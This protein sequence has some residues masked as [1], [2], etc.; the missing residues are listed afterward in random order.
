MIQKRLSRRKFLY[1]ASATAI[2]LGAAASGVWYYSRGSGP[3]HPIKIGLQ[4]DLTGILASW[5]YW[6]YKATKAAVD[7]VNNE[8]GING[9][10]VELIVEDT[11]S[12]PTIGSRKLRKLVLEDEVDFVIGTVHSGA[13]L[14]SAP[15]AKELKT[16]YMPTAMAAEITA[17][18]GNRY[19]F[20]LNS[21][22]RIQAQVLGRW[23]VEKLA[24][25]WTICVTDYAWGWSHRDWFERHVTEAGGKILAK[26]N[27]P[28]G[29][30]DFIPFINKIPPETEAIY[31]VFL[32]T[33]TL[34]FVQQLYESGYKGIKCAPVCTYETVDL[35]KLG[36]VVENTWLLEYLPRYLAELD[37]AP[38]RKFREL[39]GVSPDGREVGDPSKVIAGSHY[40]ANFEYVHL[41]KEAIEKIGWKTKADNPELIRTLEG[42]S[43]KESFRYPQGDAFIR[44][45]DHQGF[46]RHWLS[47]VENGKIKVKFEIPIKDV[48][49]PAPVDYRKEA[50]D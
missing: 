39:V 4:V 24:K 35:E 5:G 15:I 1:A 45:E 30:K 48:I 19:V 36:E 29:T 13:M 32:T 8:G 25:K 22:A 41:L 20:K 7:M 16:I 11:G 47:H 12:D 38:H 46:H 2:G 31:H 27:I 17:E 14:A 33:D 10:P 3:T 49:Y 21:H 18:R 50:F 28:V 23:G 44:P 40:W 42:I 6:Q 9:R 26:I 34:G 37:T 43:I